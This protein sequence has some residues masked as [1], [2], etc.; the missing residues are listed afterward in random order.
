MTETDI[1][2]NRQIKMFLAI[3]D[4]SMILYNMHNILTLK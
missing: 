3:I 4:L 1:I 2:N